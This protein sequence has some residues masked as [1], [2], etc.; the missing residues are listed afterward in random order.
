ME[1]VHPGSASKRLNVIGKILL[2]DGDQSKSLHAAGTR[3][4]S[5]LV[6]MFL[7]LAAPACLSILS[8]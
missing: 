4:E 3:R 8:R 1:K 5:E 2:S 6:E 7:Y